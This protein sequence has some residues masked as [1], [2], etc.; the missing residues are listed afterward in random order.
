MTWSNP[1]HIGF[2]GDPEVELIAD[3]GPGLYHPELI[4]V[5]LTT[6]YRPIHQPGYPTR[7]SPGHMLQPGM[8]VE[9]GATL[10]LLK[11]EADALV[12][13]NAATYS[14][15]PPPVAQVPQP[16][17]P[18]TPAPYTAP[19]VSSPAGTVS[20]NVGDTLTTTDG[21]WQH[22]PTDFAYQ[23]WRADP[24]TWASTMIRGAITNAYITQAADDGMYVF[25]NLT[26]SNDAGS[27]QSAS[28]VIAVGAMPNGARVAPP[29]QRREA[30]SGAAATSGFGET[31]ETPR[32]RR[33]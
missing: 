13:A 14:D 10:W 22:A 2:Y 8:T 32:R 3:L 7:N 30:A 25:C 4:G 9:P 24:V 12:A 23:W 17:P 19:I 18:V 15:M 28:N 5:T 33:G 26:G 20:A 29:A 16:L 31:A 11:P 6:T 21:T 27:A 1:Q